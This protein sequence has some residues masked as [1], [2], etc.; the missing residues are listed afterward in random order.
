MIAGFGENEI[1]P[2]AVE[3]RLEA[4]VSGKLKVAQIQFVQASREQNAT[5]MPFVQTRNGKYFC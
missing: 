4:I 2:S 5:I 1:F 3:Y